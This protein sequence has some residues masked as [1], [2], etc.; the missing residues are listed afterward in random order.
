VATIGETVPGYLA[1]GWNGLVGPA[2]M[3]AAII[4]KILTTTHRVV[5]LPE[6]HDKLI[7]LGAEPA[8]STPTEFNDLMK[9]ELIKWARVVKQSGATLD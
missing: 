9:A 2:G 7:G 5:Q 6:I 8:L 3:P 4:D 1:V